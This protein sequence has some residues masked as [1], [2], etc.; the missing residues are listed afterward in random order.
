M[1]SGGLLRAS[2]GH[3]GGAPGG[4]LAAGLLPYGLTNAAALQH[5]AHAT[6][7][8][9]SNQHQHLGPPFAQQAHPALFC[10]DFW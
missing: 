3:A 10:G 9:Y 1:H 5:A 4:N 2:S 7:P 8:M 6:R